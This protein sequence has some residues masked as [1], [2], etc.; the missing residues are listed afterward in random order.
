MPQKSAAK[1]QY[2]LIL[3]AVCNTVWAC[4]EDHVQTI[5]DIMNGRVAGITL[6]ESE[7]RARIGGEYQS[8]GSIGLLGIE[9]V[10]KS[11]QPGP[12][13]I[14]GVAVLPVHGVM[15]PRMSAFMHVS[16][17]TSTQQLMQWIED[18]ATNPKVKHILLDIDSPGGDAH[19]NQE[20]VDL[21]NEVKQTV[22]IHGH[23]TNLV[24][25]A[26]F[27]IFKACTTTSASPSTELGSVG[28]YFVH[29][30][31]SKANEADG[32][33]YT[34]F[35]GGSYKNA[36]N[37]HEPLN[38]KGREYIT[39]RIDGMY[40]QFVGSVAKCCGMSMSEVEQQF[41]A[42]K[43]Y[44]AD[45]A[46]R[47]G[48]VDRIATLK[49][50]FNE[51][52]QTG[53]AAPGARQTISA[54][55]APQFSTKE[56]TMNPL[57]RNAAIA[58]GLAQEDATDEV[59]Q[60]A[61]N[62]FFHARAESPPDDEKKLATILLNPENRVSGKIT[63]ATPPLDAARIGRDAISADAARRQDILAAGKLIGIDDEIIAECCDD[64]TCTVEQAE[65]QFKRLAVASNQPVGVGIR[66][67]RS[68]E[69]KFAAAVVDGLFENHAR[70]HFDRYEARDLDKSAIDA[71]NLSGLDIV[72]RCLNA[73]ADRSQTF[74]LDAEELAALALR[75]D[76]SD[77][78]CR[79]GG[80][81]NEGRMVSATT[82]SPS[83]FPN[84]MSNLTGRVINEAMKQVESTY[85]GWAKR[86]EEDLKDHQPSEIID[87]GH[88]SEFDQVNDDRDG[89]EDTIVEEPNWIQAADYE[90]RLKLTP[91][92]IV[93]GQLLTFINW[94]A[95]A[96][97]AHERTINR[98][99]V[100]QLVYGQTGDGKTLFHTDH[101]NKV[102][103]GGVPS[104]TEFQ[105]CRAKLRAQ[106]DPGNQTTLGLPLTSIL[107]PSA[108]E[109]DAEKWLNPDN[110]VSP[111]SDTNGNTFR[112]KLSY[113]IEP[114]LDDLSAV[115]W[116]GF[117][118][119]M[120]AAA[121]MY[122][123]RRGYRNMRRRAYVDPSTQ[124]RI[125]V[126]EGSFATA[127]VNWRGAVE[128]AGQ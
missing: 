40:R 2:P 6:S 47:R 39:E 33:T 117:T 60:A 32:L 101:L 105:N 82:M 90:K 52:R 54:A 24:A 74:G 111:T 114:M 50:V 1:R 11:D 76:G 116:Y 73:T 121:V 38:A 127:A 80:L 103:S 78:Y 21:I 98:A 19:G 58:A 91:Y 17:G 68:A 66:V 37:E 115:K 41:G 3:D 5:A 45:E 124:A 89:A 13:I 22:P 100:N 28:T 84:I 67:N 81:D 97:A 61:I 118:S 31:A 27:Y 93:N 79:L 16:G 63:D 110:R 88:L 20:V 56:M 120:R 35:R 123:Y 51:L 15:A 43:L 10:E 42:G 46:Q 77:F 86:R 87:T 26:G 4:H 112:G 108:L 109:T 8:N 53:K 72:S 49:Q 44:L 85:A 113:A 102:T 75:G 99:C 14:D 122:A 36:A 18:A 62:G 64:L 59:V 57:I 83:S 48:M 126:F 23:G 65:R 12:R 9:D 125:F 94:V 107:V 128:D 104:Q 119:K 96:A 55:V 71:G 70:E 69:D 29:G 106:K 25:S 30:E 92:M 95:L 34:V 7:I